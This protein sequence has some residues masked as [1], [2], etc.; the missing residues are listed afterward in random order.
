MKKQ[1]LIPRLSKDV[2]FHEFSKDSYLVHQTNYNHRIKISDETFD[3][4]SK[5]DNKKNLDDLKKEI[6]GILD[7]EELFD[8]LFIN[9]G[10]YGI[11]ESTYTKIIKSKKP[12]YLKISFIVFPETLIKKITSRLKFMFKKKVIFFILTFCLFILTFSLIK[13]FNLILIQNVTKSDWLY[14]FILGFISVTFHELGHASATSF[15]GAKHGGIGG[16]FYLFRPVY[17]ADVSDIWKLKPSQRIIVNL[18]GIYFE[19][20]TSTIYILIGFATSKS[21]LLIIGILIFLKS[22]L[23]LNPFLRS[24]GYWILSDATNIPNLHKVSRI[25]LLDFIKSIFIK[26]NH[27]M[28]STKTSL[29]ALY[30]SVNFIILIIFLS[31]SIISNPKSVLYFPYNFFIY[32]KSITYGTKAFTLNSLTQFILPLLFY[33]LVIKF[34]KSMIFGKM[35]KKQKKLLLSDKTQN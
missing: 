22:L 12:D 10:K 18:A 3:L 19:I 29:L 35:S 33:Y 9:F 14:L 16:G 34:L 21:I 27:F 23:N 28:V 30:A 32:I 15:F 13:N 1:L 26:K 11:I 25:H 4:L 17:F 7:I 8:I 2:S 24:D 6:N 31:Y 20:I 5:I